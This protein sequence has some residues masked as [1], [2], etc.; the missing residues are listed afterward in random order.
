MKKITKL[1]LIFL[2]LVCFFIWASVAKSPHDNFVHLYV[3]DVGQGDSILIE[4]GDYQILVDGGPDDKVLTELGKVM[5]TSDR[6]IEKVVLTHPHADHLTGLNQVLDRY[7]IGM[8]YTSGVAYDSNTYA[9]FLNKVKEKNISYEVPKMFEKVSVFDDG[10][11]EFLWPGDQFQD[12]T[13]EDLNNTSI[14]SK[15]CYFSACALLTGDVQ[16]AGQTEMLML[17]QNNNVSLVSDLLK[18]SHH[19]SI[20]GTNQALL[21]AVKPKF[22]VISVGADN[23]FGHPHAVVID[24][25]NANKIPFFRT[26]RDKTIEFAFSASG[27]IKK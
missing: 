1:T 16:I 4:R 27:M 2:V 9:N 12:K 22:A 10:S 15:F 17:S 6:K 18:I 23:K 24:L 11:L 26:D 14:V 13:I 20:N 7:E 21:D 8:I 5:P 3:L 25:L 19:G